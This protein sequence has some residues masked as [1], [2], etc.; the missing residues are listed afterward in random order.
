MPGTPAGVAAA[1][2]GATLPPLF[3]EA[4]A[5]LG[6]LP[7]PDDPAVFVHGDLRQDNTPW[8]DGRIASPAM[9]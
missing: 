3:A 4:T 5:R 9:Q 1:R 2:D 7:R 8:L 6:A